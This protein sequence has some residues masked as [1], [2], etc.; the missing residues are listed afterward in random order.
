MPVG[1]S[2]GAGLLGAGVSA[3]GAS[4]AADAQTK[5]AQEA[6]RVQME[7]FNRTQQNLAPYMDMGKS[8]GNMLSLIHI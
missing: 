7:M 4:K 8:A 6:A 2:I 3:W 1:A 5:A